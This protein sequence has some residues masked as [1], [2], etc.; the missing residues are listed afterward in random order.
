MPPKGPYTASIANTTLS[1]EVD[2]A[3]ADIAMVDLPTNVKAD[4]DK[5]TRTLAPGTFTIQRLFMDFQ[6]AALDRYDEATTVW[7]SKFPSEAKKAIPRYIKTYLELLKTAT[8]HVLGYDVTMKNPGNKADPTPTFPPTSLKYDVNQY[9]P[10]MN[11][12]PG[13]TEWKPDL[14]CLTYDM[15]TGKSKPP[16][17]EPWPWMV[18]KKIKAQAV[19]TTHTNFT[20]RRPGQLRAAN[21]RQHRTH[22]P[23]HNA[24]IP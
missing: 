24:H 19:R 11:A 13:P 14:D 17:L 1:F 23:R 15:M 9:R 7:P 5:A 3:R 18:R 16:Y 2:L 10:N 12:N 20:P 4:V 6:S 22:L 21:P 8:G